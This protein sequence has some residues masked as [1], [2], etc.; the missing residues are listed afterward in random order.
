MIARKD[1]ANDYIT[2]Q[3]IYFEVKHNE[4]GEILLFNG[5]NNTI[6]TE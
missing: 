4:K 1:K 2:I 3:G 6:A 5:K